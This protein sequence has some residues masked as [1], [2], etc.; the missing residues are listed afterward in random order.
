MPMQTIKDG[1]TI[2]YFVVWGFMGR[3]F[4]LG[5]TMFQDSAWDN[6]EVGEEFGFVV[7]V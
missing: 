6:V 2:N 5:S 4:G 1:L 7:R 3:R